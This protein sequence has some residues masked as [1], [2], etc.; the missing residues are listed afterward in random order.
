MSEKIT[1]PAYIKGMIREAAVDSPVS[2]AESVEL[3]LN[4]HGDILGAFTLRKGLT[5]LGSQ[6]E[7]SSPVLGIAN[8]RNNL[9]TLYRALAKIDTNLYAYNGTTWS[10]IRAGLTS[11]SKMRF[12]NFIDRTFMVNGNANE[13]MQTYDGTSVSSSNVADLPQGDFIENYRSRIWVADSSDDK[14]YY[15]DVVNTDNT[16][17]GGDS[18]LQISP[19]DGE[20]L[21]GLKRTASALLAFKQNHIYRIFSVNSVDPD[22]SIFRGTYSQESI[23]E[24]KK[25]VHYHHS[26]GFYDYVNG[27]EQRE[28]S[29]PIVDIIQAI[30]RSYYENVSGWSDDDH[31]YWSIGDITL[32]GITFSN[33][34][35]VRTLSTEVWSVYSYGS[36]IRS[37]GKYDDGTNE[38]V[39]VGDD[40]GNV[41]KFNEGTTDNG[42]PIFYDLHTHW[43]YFSE[44][45]T[46][47]KALTELA[48]VHE[49]A[50]GG[51]LSYQLDT[52]AK[53]KWRPIGSL[54][55]DLYQ[56]HSLN[57]KDFTRIR[58]RFH[59]NSSGTP[60]NFRGWELL[61][62]LLG[63][64][65]KK[66]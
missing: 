64:E 3:S 61:N 63:P 25:G 31:L 56:V 57:A 7:A 17:T 53:N 38:V 41:L 62:L 29:R 59:G 54:A 13:P 1:L 48:T 10:S 39:I 34:V 24:S 20:K 43:L 40:D 55:K 2:P 45:R 46:G 19:A 49:N 37:A 50:H 6:V 33:V 11:A 32:A 16:I 23:I 35:C 8:Y 4:L 51:N 65:V 14:L 9:G 36:E 21:T 58:F 27:G 22:P 28:I 26:S 60:F 66:N 5:L 15:S 30:P 52:D 42:T 18:F 47:T 44:M 12:T